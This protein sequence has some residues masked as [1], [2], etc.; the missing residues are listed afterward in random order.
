MTK[1]ESTTE[2]YVLGTF[3]GE[4]AVVDTR[5]RIREVI[6]LCGVRAYAEKIVTALNEAERAC[7][8]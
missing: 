3:K 7:A 2:R 8:P 1:R 6:A 5:P 4:D